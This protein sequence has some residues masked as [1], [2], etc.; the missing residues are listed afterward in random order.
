MTLAL[1]TGASGML[2]QAVTARLLATG[3]TVR[4]FVR[5]GSRLP[6]WPAR[7]GQLQLAHGDAANP[8]ANLAAIQQAMRGV[9]LVF[10]LAGYLSANAPLQRAG[11]A[12]LPAPYQTINV[13]FTT[14]L[15]KAAAEAGAARFVYASSSS[16]YAL[17]APAP[18]PEEAPTRPGSHY[19]RSKLLAEAQVRA[20]QAQGLPTTI[21]RP[22][23]IYGPGDRHF[24]PTVQR[25]ARL[26]LLPLIDGGRTLLDLIYVGDVAELLWLAAQSAAAVNRIYNGGPGSPTSLRDFVLAL[27]SVTGRGPR[28][29]SIPAG[30]VRPGAALL[31]PLA[32]ALQDLHLDMRRAAAE[33]DFAPGIGL[34]EGLRRCLARNP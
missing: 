10:H 9:D 1:V 18:T 6:A 19:G 14:A 7:P 34:A 28:I 3:L 4:A 24:L 23:I 8:A 5:P 12:P 25:L 17:D 21:I 22:A 33:L 26:P 31:P 15:L 29:V 20:F 16:V 13:D 32:L 2:G 30:W 27:R 11:R